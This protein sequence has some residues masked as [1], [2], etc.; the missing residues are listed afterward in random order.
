MPEFLNTKFTNSAKLC[1]SIL[2]DTGVAL[3]PGSDF[4]FNSKKMIVRLSYTDFDGSLFLRNIQNN[5]IIDDALILK[6]APNVVEGVQ[7]LS[8]W[9]KKF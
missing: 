2:K 6:Y 8:N 3:L 4:G 9:A 5:T 1:E 7:K